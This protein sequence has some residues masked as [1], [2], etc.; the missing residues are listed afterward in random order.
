MTAN[1]ILNKLPAAFIPSAAQ[2]ANCVLQ[3][4]LAQPACVAIRDGACEVSH[5]LA[6]NPD[7]KITLSD[8]H[9]VQLMQGKLNGMMALMSGKLK[10][11]GDLGLA[12]DMLGFFDPARLA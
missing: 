11:D 1:E 7:L 8:E 5:G 12:R 2:G 6:E 10:V 3:F 4:N 9:F